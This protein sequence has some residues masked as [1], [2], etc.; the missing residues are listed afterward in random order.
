MKAIFP[1]LLRVGLVLI[2]VAA[3]AQTAPPIV[4]AGFDHIAPQQV[5]QVLVVFCKEN[6]CNAEF[7][8][9]QYGYVWNLIVG[10]TRPVMIGS[11]CRSA[12]LDYD[13]CVGEW[14]GGGKTFMDYSRMQKLKRMLEAKGAKVTLMGCNFEPEKKVSGTKPDTPVACTP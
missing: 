12:G 6:G 1:L 2:A 5:D 7:L 13:Y 11:A 14:R 9:K 4:T 3:D 8:G 10:N